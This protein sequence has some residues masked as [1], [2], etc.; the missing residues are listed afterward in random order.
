MGCERGRHG[1][2]TLAWRMDGK[3]LFARRPRRALDVYIALY[4]S[5]A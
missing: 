5:Y 4:G 1:V 3:P 2:T